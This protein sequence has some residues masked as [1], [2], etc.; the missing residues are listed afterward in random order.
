[1]DN[2]AGCFDRFHQADSVAYNPI[3]LFGIEGRADGMSKRKVNECGTR[4]F[5]SLKDVKRASHA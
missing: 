4:R 5:A 2:V 1:M 3:L